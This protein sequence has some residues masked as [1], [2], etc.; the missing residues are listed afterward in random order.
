MWYIFYSI[1]RIGTETTS[2]SL[3]ALQSILLPNDEIAMDIGR[4]M[5]Y[6]TL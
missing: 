3:Y 4:F 2:R 6:T 1:Y 5:Y